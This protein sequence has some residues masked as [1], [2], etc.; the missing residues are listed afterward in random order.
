M[1]WQKGMNA[2]ID[3]IEDNLTGTIDFN[4]AA[5]RAGCSTWEFQRRFSFLTGI[6]LGDYIRQRKLTLAA[7]DIQ[8]GGSKIIDIALSYGYES[9]AAF[10][11]AFSK[12]FGTTPVAS[13]S[14]GIN[15]E[16]FPKITF[17]WTPFRG[18][19]LFSGEPQKSVARFIMV[20]GLDSPYRLVKEKGWEHITDIEPQSWGARECA[21]T[22]PDGCILR[23]FESTP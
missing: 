7:R 10:S 16:A 4:Q 1:D 6:P 17:E 15:P 2:A 19:H 14:V 18:F 21:V 12:Q 5:R 8:T 11:R 20:E 22:T 23:F 9:P 13:R 3:Y